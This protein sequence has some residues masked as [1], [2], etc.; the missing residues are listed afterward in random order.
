MATTWTKRV[1]PTTDRGVRSK[2]ETEWDGRERPITAWGVRNRPETGWNGRVRPITYMT[3]L[4]DAYS[5]VADESDNVIYVLA[6][7]WKLIPATFWKKNP[8]FNS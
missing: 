8:L 1:R 6:D 2:P 7:S 5:E 3:P 4:E